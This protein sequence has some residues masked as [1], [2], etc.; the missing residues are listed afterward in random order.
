MAIDVVRFELECVLK[1]RY[2]TIVEGPLKMQA[3]PRPLSSRLFQLPTA[4][5]AGNVPN[6]LLL[7]DAHLVYRPGTF[8]DMDVTVPSSEHYD[9]HTR[10]AFRRHPSSDLHNRLRHW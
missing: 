10:A 5:P 9:H 4:S 7:V 3:E 2:I 1:G 6:P 8:I